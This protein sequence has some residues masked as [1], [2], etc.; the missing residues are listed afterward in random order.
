MEV[1]G[2]MVVEVAMMVVDLIRI[3]VNIN[4]YIIFLKEEVGGST[5]S[6]S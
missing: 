4:H 1:V 6:K 2:L 5:F 3:S